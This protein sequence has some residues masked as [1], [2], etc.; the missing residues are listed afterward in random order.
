LAILAQCFKR[1]FANSGTVR[2]TQAEGALMRDGSRAAVTAA[3]EGL[4]TVGVLVCVAIG[5]VVLALA[6]LVLWRTRS[7]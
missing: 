6:S 1:Y 3:A 2:F 4:G 7:R 5:V